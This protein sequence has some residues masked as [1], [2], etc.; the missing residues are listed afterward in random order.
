MIV[1]LVILIVA[2][3]G[4][5]GAYVAMQYASP[6]VGTPSTGGPRYS[7]G[8][9]SNRGGRL[10]ERIAD[11]PSG[12]LVAVLLVVAIWVALWAVVLILGLRVLTA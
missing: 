6:D 4:G 9:E 12:C 11:A 7:G 3:V 5:V 2:A 10:T 8:W 1:L